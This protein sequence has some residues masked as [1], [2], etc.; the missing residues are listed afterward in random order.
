MEVS[1][2]FRA[3]WAVRGLE[4]G[5]HLRDGAR[6]DRQ[7]RPGRGAPRTSRISSSLRASFSWIIRVPASVTRTRTMRRS[8]GTRVRSMYPRSSIRSTRPVAFETRDAE[9]VGEAAHR[10]HAVALERVHDVELGHADAQA[11]EPLAHRALHRADRDA[12]VGDDAF[13]RVVT[14]GP[15]EAD[16]CGRVNNL[17]HVN[18]GTRVNH[19][20]NM[21]DPFQ[22]QESR[23]GS[24]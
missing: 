17:C 2:R 18:Y 21:D 8:S 4:R 10:H 24:R 1:C 14:R 16:R 22:V 11:D 19:P 23:C 5:A 13:R 6:D 15:V 9:H 12:E 3:G 20:V 7:L